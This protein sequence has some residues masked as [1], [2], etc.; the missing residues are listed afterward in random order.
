MYVQALKIENFRGFT[1]M[2]SPLLFSK[3]IN[4]I[5][6][7]NNS[8]KS[9]ILRSIHYLQESNDSFYPNDISKSKDEGHIRV[10]VNDAEHLKIPKNIDTNSFTMYFGMKKDGNITLNMLTDGED[11]NYIKFSNN[12]PDNLIYPYT[13]KRKVTS[14]NP[15][16]S[17]QVTNS[18]TGNLSTLPAKTDRSINPGS[19][20]HKEYIQVC[21]DIFGKDFFFTTMSSGEGK[22]VG[23]KV[24]NYESITID[25]MGEGVASILGLINI[26]CG[27]KNKVFLIEEIENDIHPLALKS[28]LKLIESKSSTNQF[29]IS[30]HSNI[31]TKYLG[32]VVNAK[33]FK[34]SLRLENK[35]PI[36]EIEEVP[37]DITS[38]LK[39]LE[40]LGYEPVDYGF[41][42]GYLFL[43]E[44]SAESII[45]EFLIPTFAP[46][47]SNVVKTFSTK[48][49]DNVLGKFDDFNR[50]FVFLHLEPT[51]KNKVW[52]I[53]DG[54]KEE[55]E[56]IDK[57]KNMYVK[58]DGWNEKH[59]DQF[60]QHT[61]EKYYP[62][63]FQEEVEG[64]FSSIK[65]TYEKK[66]ELLKKVIDWSTKNPQDAKI[67]WGKSA[68]E[69]IEKLKEIEKHL[70]KA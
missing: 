64:I 15:S 48:G 18:V 29:F 33:V 13:A 3:N 65:D 43:E 12:E 5:V 66:I 10:V 55:K 8:G 67:E 59:F 58:E 16:I 25:R 44:S 69:V 24:N 27:A 57:L 54:G 39:V 60:P 9:T 40:D 22:N 11:T 53:I 42:K 62:Q 7:P 20:T 52:V 35:I 38:R 2:N 50:L 51:Y 46:K 41:W 70:S 63:R 19:E 6:G 4:V 14:F 31:V 17:E 30:T 21:E 56:I 47:L 45:R 68:M 49:K 26:L 36:T 32:A 37:N 1:T 28:I 34:T 61:F 23:I